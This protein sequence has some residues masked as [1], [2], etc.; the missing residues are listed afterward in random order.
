MPKYV[1]VDKET[2]IACGACALH[3]PEIFDYDDDGIAYS[4][5]DNNQGNS[6]IPEKWLENAEIAEDACPSLS[7]QIADEPFQHK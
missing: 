2:C 7:I 4:M 5:L 6:K 1:C 3:A